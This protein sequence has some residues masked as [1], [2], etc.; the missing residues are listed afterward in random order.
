MDQEDLS[1]SDNME[2]KVNE[3][4]ENGSEGSRR[5]AYIVMTGRWT[6]PKRIY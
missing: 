2:T 5:N 6:P 1:I 3:N 4:E